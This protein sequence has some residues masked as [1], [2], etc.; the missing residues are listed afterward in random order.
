MTVRARAALLGSLTTGESVAEFAARWMT[1]FPR[2]AVSTCKTYEVTVSKFVRAYGAR[3][4]DSITPV[5]AARWAREHPNQVGVLKTFYADA[6]HGPAG[7]CAATF[8]P[9]ARVRA[10]R[11]KNRRGHV[12]PTQSEVH[13]LADIALDVLPA[14]PG[15]MLRAAL[16]LGFY[17]LCRP[18]ELAALDHDH[19]DLDRGRLRIEHTMSQWEGLR[20]PKGG[21]TREAPL[22]EPARRAYA[23]V[24]RHPRLPYV[25]WTA[26]GQRVTARS[27]YSWWRKVR[28]EWASRAPGR[29]QGLVYY[30]A[31]RHAGITHLT[32]V[33]GMNSDRVAL[34][35]GHHDGGQLVRTLYAHRDTDQALRD[36]DQA[37]R[38]SG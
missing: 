24:L 23:E 12:P 8:N 36:A 19:V 5:E 7:A 25:L 29:D 2:P 37:W 38:A 21:Y 20:P 30:V 13:E 35:A 22:P 28:D 1:D 27:M 33:L 16:L 6:M 3:P 10:P 32:E 15:L 18:G 34:L 17:T 26:T 31:T 11:A 4:L 9:F 14:V